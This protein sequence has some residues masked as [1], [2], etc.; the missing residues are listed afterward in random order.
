MKSVPVFGLRPKRPQV[1]DETT[2]KKYIVVLVEPRIWMLDVAYDFH[3]LEMFPVA[4]AVAAENNNG[5]PCVI[6]RTPKPVALMAG[7]RFGQPVFRSQKI[8]R[9][10]LTVVVCENRSVC[11]FIS[12]QAVID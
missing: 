9:A 3:G 7:D 1:L 10:G 2:T 12:G 11:A 5:I 4:A 6:A 8:N